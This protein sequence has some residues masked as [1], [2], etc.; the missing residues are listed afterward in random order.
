M[1][2]S[3][4]LAAQLHEPRGLVGR[5]VGTAM[6]LVNR[7]PNRLALEALAL[8]S[9]DTVLELGFGPGEAIRIFDGPEGNCV[10]ARRLVGLGAVDLVGIDLNQAFVDRDMLD[11]D[12][13]WNRV[14]GR[15]GE[16]RSSA[17]LK[18]LQNENNLNSS[19]TSRADYEID[20]PRLIAKT[21]KAG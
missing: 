12:V 17:D 14:L 16:I 8:G 5:L 6:R 1:S 3:S 9:G 7:A 10:V 20:I 4:S 11:T 21:G 13:F 2:V 18:Q 19:D 15:R